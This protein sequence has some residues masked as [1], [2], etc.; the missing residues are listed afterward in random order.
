M[1]PDIGPRA[2]IADLATCPPWAGWS[3]RR[4]AKDKI[5]AA[6][7]SLSEPEGPTQFCRAVRVSGCRRAVWGMAGV[8]SRQIK[9]KPTQNLCTVKRKPTQKLCTV[10]ECLRYTVLRFFFERT[11]L[12]FDYV[13]L[14]SEYIAS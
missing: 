7:S 2:Q 6:C 9:T 4:A 3:I 11:V 14:R 8:Y 12:R 10:K 1:Y 5:W 13:L